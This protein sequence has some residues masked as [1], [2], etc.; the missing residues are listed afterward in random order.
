MYELTDAG[1]ELAD[2]LVVPLA[3]WG[4]RHHLDPTRQEDQRFRPEWSLAV[5]AR[6]L[7]TTSP[8]SHGLYDFVID[9]E[10][11]HIT[12]SGEQAEVVAGPSPRPADATVST[13][14]ATIASLVAG[15]LPLAEAINGGGIVLTGTDEA[16]Q[17]LASAVP[18]TDS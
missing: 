16:L 10:H 12:Q 6:L 18:D 17:A 11:A 13:D 3:R 1:W 2:A 14:S 4:A 15:R 9:G 7:A 8:R 5:F